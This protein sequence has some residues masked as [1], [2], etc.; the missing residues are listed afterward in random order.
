MK[1]QRGRERNSSGSAIGLNNVK[2]SKRDGTPNS[3]SCSIES[4]KNDKDKGSSDSDVSPE[5]EVQQPHGRV[6]FLARRMSGPFN[7]D[8]LRK[9]FIL[10]LIRFQALLFNIAIKCRI[11]SRVL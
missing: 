2:V 9:T 1:Y 5:R 7:D 3:S 6:S 8:A 10:I 4:I 11:R